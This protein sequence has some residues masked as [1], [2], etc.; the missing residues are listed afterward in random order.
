VLR[1]NGRIVQTGAG[2]AVLGSPLHA[3]T[4]LANTLTARGVELAAGEVILTGSVTAAVP[5]S[6]GDTVTAS[7]DRLGSV[8]AVFSG[9]HS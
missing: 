8:T 9:D 5:V 1:H 2:A 7:F 6:A 4:W 3:A